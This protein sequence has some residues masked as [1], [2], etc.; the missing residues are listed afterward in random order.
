MATDLSQLFQYAP[1]TA[2]YMLGQSQAADLARQMYE[3]QQIQA[4]T[5]DLQQKTAENAEMFPLKKSNQ[6]LQNQTLSAQLPGIFTKNSQDALNLEKNQATKDSDIEATKA[7]NQGKVDEEVMK[8]AQQGQQILMTV[9][10]QLS[11]VP[12]PLRRQHLDAVIKNMKLNE[13]S[14]VIQMLRSVDPQRMPE[15]AQTLAARAGAQALAMNPAAQASMY[16]H[17]VT[18]AAS[19]YDADQRR[20][21]EVE[22]AQIRADSLAKARHTQMNA[23]GILQM[24]VDGKYSFEKAL[25][26]LT[27]LGSMT[28]SDEEKSMIDSAM[29]TIQTMM[30]NKAAAGQTGKMTLQPDANGNMQLTPNTIPD[31]VV[32]E[33]VG[34][35]RQELAKTQQKADNPLQYMSPEERKTDP[36]GSQARE[37]YL[38]DLQA[39]QAEIHR[40]GGGS[41]P[42]AKS[43]QPQT[44]SGTK[45]QIISK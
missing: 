30:N 3:Q 41:S 35:L 13:D 39:L 8:R 27:V 14:P 28:T 23:N 33:R 32:P 1:T 9:G 24:A 2:G 6:D 11:G 37:R 29:R 7:T 42:P 16:G 45:Y 38:R 25:S 36:D 26:A 34:I 5:A 43:N 20:G 15:I 18:S 4:Q 22:A 21:G 31:P 12:A 40:V 44:K 19:R 17:D 10:T